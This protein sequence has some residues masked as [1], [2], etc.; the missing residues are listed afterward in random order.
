MAN[1][2][3]TTLTALSALQGVAP[4]IRPRTYAGR[5]LLWLPKLVGGALSPISG[6]IGTLAALIGLTRRDWPLTATGILGAG[7][8]ARLAADL[9]DVD[10]ALAGLPQPGGEDLL[11][12]TEGQTRGA[13]A[14]R[15]GPVRGSE[16]E[17]HLVLGHNSASGQALLADLWPPAGPNPSGLG[18]IY[19]HGSGWCVGDKDQGTRP[20]FR[21]LTG[22][23][24]LVLDIA[25]SLWPAATLPGM[26][27]EVNQAIL[28]LKEHGPAFGVQPD[29]IVLV[30][31]SAGG[32]LALMAA[33]TPGH[34][35]FQP[36]DAAGDTSVR[37][38]IAFYPPVDLLV[39]QDD[40]TTTALSS[41]GLCARLA[42][43]MLKGLFRVQE[44][45]A[46]ETQLEDRFTRMIGGT[47]AGTPDAARL[48]SPIHH[49]GAHCPPTLLLQ[50]RDDVFGLAP[51]VRRLHERLRAAGVPSALLEFPHTEHAFDLVLPR[52]SPSARA[53][54]RAVEQFLARLP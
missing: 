39:W 3:L 23:G 2:L 38:V 26:V 40:A 42:R 9:P 43:A 1:R 37:A 28:W 47:A 51:G 48:L 27:A 46:P 20:F 24:H 34:P 8:A 19:A 13:P 33:Y 15:H 6:G 18:L 53:A 41:S 31:G 14:R 35:A 32:H 36:P 17:R 11:P 29:R 7:L 10:Q 22:R 21:R 30:G 44:E 5:L 25:Y 52:I 4:F 45:G 16:F 54:T 50:G 49:V 12:T